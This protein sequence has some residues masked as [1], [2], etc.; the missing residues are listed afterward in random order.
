MGRDIPDIG[1]SAIA[2]YEPP[3]ILGNDWFEGT[4]PR[5]FLQHTG[6][7]SRRVAV[8][9]ELTLAVRAV[10]SLQRETGC[11]LS[12]CAAI[13]FA[14][15]S[16]VPLDVARKY[17]DERG[18]RQEH[19]P[20]A[21]R[22]LACRLGIATCPALG[23]NWF[24]S[25]YSKALAM[26][27]RRMV[28]RLNLG[29][30]QFVL[31][32]T[33]SRISRITDYSCQQSAALFGDLATATLLAR[34][35]SRRYPLHF[36]LLHAHA[37]RRPVAKPFFEFHLRDNVLAPAVDGGRH[38]EPHRLVFSLDGMGIAE[39]APRAMAGAIADALAA[40]GMPPEDVRFVLPHQAGTSIVRFTAMKVEEFGIRGEVLGD[41]TARVGNVSSGSIP[42]S[43]RK[44]W[45]R[46]VGTIVCP[47]AAVGPPGVAE[48][49]RG[50]VV[51]RATPRHERLALAAA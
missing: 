37:H 21:A 25:G 43:L 39:V 3:W 26:V 33:S 12:D 9:D 15:P 5:K 30:E 17:L 36:R 32:I 28:P 49:S 40:T 51:L 31:V 14:S 18:V 24:C 47:T 38:Y 11:D 19:L 42:Y 16:Y 35:D 45:L 8:E 23:I 10:R 34:C 6:T 48:I 20:L 27:S 41:L 2:T 4:I 50:C 29:R 7:E 46:L 13:V 22:H 1:I 44:A